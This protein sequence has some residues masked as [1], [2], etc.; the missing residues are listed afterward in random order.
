MRASAES[1]SLSGMKNSRV[2]GEEAEYVDKKNC[3]V[4]ATRS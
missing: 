3:S 2:L 1:S 4:P